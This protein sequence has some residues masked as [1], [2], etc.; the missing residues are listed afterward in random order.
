[1]DPSDKVNQWKQHPAVAE[2][3][4]GLSSAL[5]DKLDGVVLYGPAARDEPVADATDLHLLI[6]LGDLELETLATAGPAIEAW[7]RGDEADRVRG[8]GRAAAATPGA[9]RPFP[10]LF[11]RRSLAQAAD[12]FPIELAEIAERHLVLHGDSP[13]DGM[14]PV[15]TEHLRLQCERELREKLMRL[16]EAYALSRGAE[17]DLGTLLVASY[18]TFTRVFRGCLRLHGEAP[19]EGSLEAARAFCTLAEI[20]PAPFAAVD[21]MRRGDKPGL[22][23]AAV[24]DR[25]HAAIARAVGAVDRFHP[26]EHA[27]DRSNEP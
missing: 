13:L 24:F 4:S 17:A 25:Y 14:P 12:V 27:H 19:P 7:V 23:V 11:T 20:D 10:R 1:M 3:L 16:E 21:R 8:R 26:H 22:S 18:P 15:E 9:M 6:V 5:G 2:L